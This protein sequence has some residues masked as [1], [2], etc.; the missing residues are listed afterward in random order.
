MK[1]FMRLMLAG[2]ILFFPCSGFAGAPF[3]LG[4]APHT[5]ARII[6][7]MY[8]PFRVYLQQSLN[9]SVEVVTAPD[10][11][12]FAR[13][14]LAGDYDLAVTTGHQARL[15][16]TDAGY[17]PLLTYKADFKAVALVAKKGPIHSPEDLKEMKALGLSPSSLVTLWGRHWLAENGLGS[18]SVRYVSASDSV[19]QLVAAGDAAVGFTSL[20]NFLK[21][22]PELQAQLRI[23]AESE[24]MAGRVYLLNSRHC[25][26]EKE[27]ATALWGFAQTEEAKRYFETNNL[28]GYRKLGP[29]ELEAMDGYAAEVRDTLLGKGEE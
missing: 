17:I 18:T 8:Q 25:A 6:L 27:I 9:R 11:S 21:L 15:M 7:E 4:V 26:M 19:A 1:V 2:W 5:S 12:D 24:T 28:G 22:S 13:R 3:I 16:Q 23:L 20:T 14:A 29:N 10:F